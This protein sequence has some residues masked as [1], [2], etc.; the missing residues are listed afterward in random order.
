MNVKYL[1]IIFTLLILTASAYSKELPDIITGKWE[2][3]EVH[4]NTEASRTPLYAWNDPRLVGRIF[5]FESTAISNNTPENF[6]CSK[7]DVKTL[8]TGLQ[9]LIS[10]SMAGYGYPAKKASATD[11]SLNI[12]LKK[13]FEVMRIYCDGDL[14]NGTLGIDGEVQGSWLFFA[15]TTRLILRWYD[16]TILVLIKIQN[17]QLPT[18]SYN[19]LKSTTTTEH[20]ICQSIELSSFDRSVSQAYKL[21]LSEYRSTGNNFN[22]LIRDQQAW[23]EERNR[24]S[25]DMKCITNSMRKRL[26]ELTKLY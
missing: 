17:N 20:E 14:W 19:C 7:P 9:N 4:I 8:I 12:N 15:N 3:K 10:K 5:T 11:Y 2:V 23:L 13:N 26:D 16:E 24:C 6:T 21:A 25:S 18:P 1:F 22:L